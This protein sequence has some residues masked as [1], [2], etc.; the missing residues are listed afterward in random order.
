MTVSAEDVLQRPVHVAGANKTYG[1]VTRADAEAHGSEL[2]E[3]AGWGPTARVA[4]IARAWEQLA[5]VL[6]EAGAA[7]VSE[8]GADVVVDYAHKLWIVI[9]PGD[10]L[11]P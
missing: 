9:P 6:D 7:T 4:P 1:E 10:S 2:K 5:G 8:L 3:L 11:T